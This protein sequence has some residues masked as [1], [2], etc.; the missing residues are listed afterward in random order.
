MYLFNAKVTKIVDG[1]TIDAEVDLGFHVKMNLRF[2]LEGIDTPELRTGDN[3][4]AAQ[5]AKRFLENTILG[6]NVKI[7]SSKGDK[8]GRWLA[9]VILQE[10]N[11]VNKLLVEK[12][13]AK[14]YNG[15]TKE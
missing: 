12:G 2:R 9:T 3:K 14:N 6:A 1:D 11:S 15:G 13:F 4:E 10:G 8:Y 5:E 7:M